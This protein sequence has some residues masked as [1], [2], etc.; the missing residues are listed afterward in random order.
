MAPNVLLLKNSYPRI[1]NFFLRKRKVK[2]KI[3]LVF[4]LKTM[5]QEYKINNF[6]TLKL[7]NNDTKIFVNN[8]LFNHCKI[9]LLEIPEEKLE[10]TE[11]ISSIDEAKDHLSRG[12]EKNKFIIEPEVAFFGHCSNLQA[13]A[14]NN[15]DTRLL[16][17]NLSF[18]LLFIGL[19]IRLE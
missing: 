5:T 9:L 7:E 14:E 3:N 11:D 12:M 8:Q 19:E 2:I 15:Y 16:H 17:S 10:T 6:I 13:W 4:P 1:I 18:P